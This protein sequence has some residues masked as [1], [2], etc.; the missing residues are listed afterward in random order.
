MPFHPLTT[1]LAPKK[2]IPPLAAARMQHW[3]LF[4]SAYSYE[5]SFH[6]TAA[7]SKADGLSRLL[8]VESD[9]PAAFVEATAVNLAQL[10]ALPLRT[11]EIRVATRSD[12]LLSQVLHY[13]KYGWPD[14]IKECLLPYWRRRYKLTVEGDCVLWGL[15]VVVPTKLQ[16][17]VLAELHCGHP[18]VV[19]MKEVARS[20]V[21]WPK[22]DGAFEDRAK[23][24]SACPDNKHLL[25]KAPLYCWPWPSAQWEHIHVDYAGPVM[26]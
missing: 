15:R 24:C 12:R 8:T 4:L 3:A 25:P 26:G 10:E 13:L 6:P 2:G 18:G 17:K 5:I 9:L 1:I 20:H 11:S 16:S 19:W 22:L 21:W 23:S 14:K 7:H